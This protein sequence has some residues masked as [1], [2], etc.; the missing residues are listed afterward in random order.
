LRTN[1]FKK[2]NNNTIIF[3]KSNTFEYW[4]EFDVDRNHKKIAGELENINNNSIELKV[5]VYEIPF[6][7]FPG[8][9]YGEF[10]V[11][12]IDNDSITLRNTKPSQ[13]G[14]GNETSILGGG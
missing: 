6:E 14:P 1:F 2:I 5:M 10:E 11:N 3:L 8:K 12:S 9:T 7:I 13:F 4:D